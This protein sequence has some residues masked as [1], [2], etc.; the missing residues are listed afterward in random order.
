MGVPLVEYPINSLYK[1]G[2]F[3]Q[4]V[5]LARYLRRNGIGI[6]HTYNFYPNVFG[7]PAARLAGVP[8]IVASIRDTGAYLNPLQ[9]RA[10]RMVCSMADAIV[11]N[12]ARAGR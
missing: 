2:T 10:Q 1:W 6:V 11:A 7:I 9:A 4:Q 3:R 12:A 8:R 5:K